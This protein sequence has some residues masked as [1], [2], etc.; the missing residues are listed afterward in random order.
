[1]ERAWWLHQLVKMSLLAGQRVTRCLF[2]PCPH[3]IL[4][5]RPYTSRALYAMLKSRS[6]Q[7]GVLAGQSPHGLRRGGVQAAR[8]A[9]HSRRAIKARA[10]M[11]LDATHDIYA[12]PNRHLPEG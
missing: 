7:A 6:G 1:M 8:M 3:G 11:Q 10:R 5:E 2:Q 9:G 4:C 12:D